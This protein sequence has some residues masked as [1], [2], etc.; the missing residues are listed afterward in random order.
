M[1]TLRV[2]VVADDPLSANGALVPFRGRPDIEIL[3][4]SRR[5]ETQVL[6][7]ITARVDNDTID[8][9]RGVAETC[10]QVGVVLVTDLVPERL[11]FRAIDCGLV[12]VLAR[13]DA[14]AE[15][16]VRAVI[17]AAQ[18]HPEMPSRVLHGLIEQVRRVQRDVLEPN[19]LTMGGLQLREVEVLRLLADGSD[20]L[21]IA[22]QLNYSE[23]TV[24]NV[25]H[26]MMKRLNLR[27]RS[28]AVAFGLRCGA[29]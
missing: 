15:R 6:V 18:G 19:D 7:V 13:H 5:H 2:T 12:S 29:L 14:S 22:H 25:L 1:A 3:P 8:L 21:E 26:A 27:N 9:I 17:G 20:T 11:L 16:L 10:D 28:H 24:K 4:A 23:R